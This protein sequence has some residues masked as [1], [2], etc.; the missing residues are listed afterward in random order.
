M[1][2]SPVLDREAILR[3]IARERALVERL[4]REG[5]E[6][7]SRLRALEAE[8]ANDNLAPAQFLPRTPADK[9]ALF[10]SLFRGR[11]DVFPRYWR[12]ERTGRAGYAPACANEWVP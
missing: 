10:R 8:V 4:D 6:A 11:D 2:S 12:N 1:T 5:E 7:R 3:E 9:V